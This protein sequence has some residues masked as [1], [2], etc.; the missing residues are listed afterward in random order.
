M[1]GR[2]VGVGRAVGLP[3]A[4]VVADVAEV[5]TEVDVGRVVEDEVG[6]AT[7]VDATTA[8]DG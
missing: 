1:V 4:F 5:G 6:S 3:F 8:I 7:G 2:F